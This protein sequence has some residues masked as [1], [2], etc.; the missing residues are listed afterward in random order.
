MADDIDFSP[1]SDAE[2]KAAHEQ[3]RE[4]GPET[5]RP[6]P[7]SGDA[8][9]PEKASARL[10]G[11]T[12]D[13]MWPYRNAKGA[14]DF[15]VCRWNFVRAGNPGKEIRPLHRS[16]SEGWRFEHLPAPRP[17][18]NLDQLT[19][20][21]NA[22]V[23]VC[24]GEPPADA[25]GELFRDH[26]VVTSCGGA[27]AA[28]LSDWTPL[29]GRSVKIWR[30]NDRPG[31]DYAR[32][33]A[34]ILSELEC[35]VAIVEVTALVAIDGGAREADFDPDG[36]DAA[37]A[38]KQWK[39]VSALRE[40]VLKLTKPFDPAP[41]FVS[42]G[43]YTMRATGLT[44]ERWNGK[45]RR[46]EI[47]GVAAP[48]EVR[49]LCR[50]PHGDRWGKVLRWRDGDGLEHAR[51][52]TDAALQGDPSLLCASLADGGLRID[53]TH[54]REFARYLSQ[55]EVKRRATVVPQTG[56]H[57]IGGRAVFVLPG[58]TIG[59]RGRESVM[60]ENATPHGYGVRGTLD[61]WRDSVAKLAQGHLLAMLA[62]SAA[63]SGPLL[64]LTRLEGGGVHLFGPSST[65]KS[66][67]L[68]MAASVWGPP[69]F[70]RS[71]RATAN[72]LEGAA[73]IAN[74]TILILDELGQVEVRELAAAPYLLSNGVGKARAA[75][76][77]SL[78]D[79]KTWRVQFF[80]SGEIPVDAKLIE[81]KGRKPRAG[82]LIRML[83]VPAS[84]ACGVFD[85]D[86]PD[87]DAASLAK[88]CARAAAEAS[89]PP[90]RNSFGGSWLRTLAARMCDRWSTTSSR[91]KSPMALT[92]RFSVWLNAWA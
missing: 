51:F 41:A 68:R 29:A 39:D 81:E 57:E 53:R 62:I 13:R 22:P 21:P 47:H 32:D 66:T 73:T 4:A 92:V 84:R 58:G 69:G 19:V 89:A 80:S 16:V 26:V 23:I 6:R 11:R 48:F 55:V 38:V 75:R 70:V 33:V 60:L 37:D 71:W 45:A 8:E 40:T 46:T 87:G 79:S 50:D 49:G 65:G 64:Y 35:D 77:G 76:D 15:W 28:K 30:D 17:L 18:Y 3:A 34:E 63:L 12:P 78:R 1:L 10:F 36:W 27:R 59:P 91:R 67:L 72:G 20:R 85:D 61:E 83:N 42:F 54:Q 43:P 56:W 86:G 82:Q 44:V 31:E 52:V 14:I 90:G 24:E 9:G 74:D 88:T 25:A 5:G 7:S 2:R